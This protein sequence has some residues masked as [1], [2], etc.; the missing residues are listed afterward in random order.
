MR[1]PVLPPLPANSEFCIVA[2]SGSALP[3]R[4][5]W[6][7]FGILA[8]V[9]A[10]A[11]FTVSAWGAWL[12]L[13][14]T[15]LEIAALAAAFWW[16]E[17]RSRDWE[18]L[19]VA[20]NRVIIERSMGGR[21]DKREFSRHWVQVNMEESTAWPPRS[22]LALRFAGNTVEFGGALGSAERA[23]VARELRR[24]LTARNN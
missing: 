8:A 5:R 11:G 7:S 12:V 9:S 13:P 15:A 1:D 21:R 18:R 14:Y 17:R 24:V 6:L 3:T 20:E 2:R 19:T 4:Q 23:R 16:M 22:R 10:C